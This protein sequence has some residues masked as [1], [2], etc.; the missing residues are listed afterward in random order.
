M[1][2]SAMEPVR[3]HAVFFSDPLQKLRE[4][5]MNFAAV[6]SQPDVKTALS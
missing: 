2:S 1:T 6:A 4:R 5:R 3:N